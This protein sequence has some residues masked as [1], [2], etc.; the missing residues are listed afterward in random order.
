MIEYK[1]DD[2][3]MNA[4]FFVSFVNQIWQGDYNIERTQAALSKTINITYY[5][6]IIAASS[7]LSSFKPYFG[8]DV[9]QPVI[10]ANGGEYIWIF[11]KS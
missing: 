3:E 2:K 11:R 8:N 1:V 4:S 7:L 6:G 5:D 10:A 9:L